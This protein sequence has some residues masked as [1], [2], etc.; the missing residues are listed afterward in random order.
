MTVR[1]GRDCRALRERERV[2]VR[3]EERQR[4]CETVSDGERGLGFFIF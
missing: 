4:E 3:T 1:R 2:P